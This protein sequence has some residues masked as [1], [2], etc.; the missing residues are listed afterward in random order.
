MSDLT[1]PGLILLIDDNPN[2]RLLVKR[3]LNQAFGPLKF[4]EIIDQSDFDQALQEVPFELVITDYQLG[5]STGIKVLR[6]VRYQRPKCPVIMF[7]NTGTEEIAV[8]AMKAGLNDYV[9][10]SP[11]H[12]VRLPQALQSVWQQHLGEQE[13]QQ[14]KQELQ[15]LNQTLEIRIQ[16]R[17][18]ALEQAN[19]ELELFTASISHDLR[20]PIRQIDGFV[21]LLRE[22]LSEAPPASDSVAPYLNTLSGLADKAGAMI[23]LLLDFSRLARI[24]LKC[25]WVDMTAIVQRLRAAQ[26]GEAESREIQWE[27]EPLPQVWCDPTLIELVWQNLIENAVKFTAQE[28]EP[29]ICITAT[30]AESLITFCIKD[31]GVGFSPTDTESIFS[32]FQQ[33]HSTVPQ[34]GSRGYGIGLAS[35]RRIVERHGGQTWAESNLQKGALFYFSLPCSSLV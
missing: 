21:E 18:A 15:E 19:R 27:I 5:W 32:V 2:D 13:I 35:V 8:E 26:K 9:V 3:A 23:D 22:Q 11:R 6:Q 14:T 25:E 20:S 12:F 31:N 29:K 1:L 34:S 17:T 33:S 4:K 24:E 10:K 16:E 30:K 28:A 7:T